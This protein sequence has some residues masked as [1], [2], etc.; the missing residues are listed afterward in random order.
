M[1]DF[2]II[3]IDRIRPHLDRKKVV[4]AVTQALI[5]QAEGRV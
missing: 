1:S 4:E 2:E 5:L 3:G